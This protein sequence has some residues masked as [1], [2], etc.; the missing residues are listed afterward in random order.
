MTGKGKGD[1]EEKEEG[2]GNQEKDGRSQACATLSRQ[3]QEGLSKLEASSRPTRA[4]SGACIETNR[5]SRY[6]TKSNGAA[7]NHEE[8]DSAEKSK[9]PQQ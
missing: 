7:E 1:K 2:T 6:I 9:E 3:R 8:I 4:L 5:N